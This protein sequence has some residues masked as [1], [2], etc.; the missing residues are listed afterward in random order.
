MRPFE[1]MKVIDATHVI[2]GPYATYL[3]AALGAE[4]IKVEP[5]GDPDQTRGQGP[6]LD[7]KQKG[8][9]TWYL[10]QSADKQC[11]SLDLK[12]PAG[13]E[14][15]KRLIAGAD[16]L[17]ENYRPGAFAALGFDT[18]S[19]H[20]LNPRLIS[21]SLSAYGQTGPRAT[22]TG[23][24]MV[25]QASS[26]LMAMTGTP[27]VNPMKIGAPV[28][29]YA[30]GMSMAFAISSA[31]LQRERTGKGQQIDL[32]MFDVALTLMG[33]FATSHSYSG[34]APG[35][36]GNRGPYPTTGCY[37]TADGLL[38]LGA[39]NHRQQ[40]RL[41]EALGHPEMIKE[42]DSAHTADRE[43]EFQLLTELLRARTAAQW[44]EFLQ[45]SHVP[46]A[47]VRVLADALQ[48][49][50]LASRRAFRQFDA[51]Q[52]SEAPVQVPVAP[53]TFAHGGPDL[54]RAPQPLGA[55]NNTILAGLGY[56]PA[57]IAQ[58]RAARVI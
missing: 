21:C 2:A 18:D 16:V 43:P 27:E 51:F 4:V 40:R 52:G 57:D 14:V 49:P 9:G 48:D 38:M 3:L 56:S 36:S 7:L 11:L 46:A 30:T 44:E 34:Q 35:P 33:L 47:K 22:Q 54:S 53:F 41:W 19:L 26:G 25:I 55:D 58:M 50:Q 45:S 15:M 24:D 23:Y 28:I 39:A 6:S 12:T 8:M 10:S 17:V 13:K 29:D 1:G 20:A 37:A 32:A 42:G 31:L 5:P